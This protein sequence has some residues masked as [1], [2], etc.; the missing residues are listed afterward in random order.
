MNSRHGLTRFEY[1]IF[2]EDALAFD[3]IQATEYAMEIIEEGCENE[4]I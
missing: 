1:T 4:E 2:V 3:R